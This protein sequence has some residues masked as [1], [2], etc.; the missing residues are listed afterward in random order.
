MKIDLEQIRCHNESDP[1]GV[2]AKARSVKRRKPLKN[3]KHRETEYPL[4]ELSDGDEYIGAWRIPKGWVQ[5]AARM[6]KKT[7]KT[8]I[9]ALAI[10]AKAI[11][12]KSAKIE[13]SSVEMSPWGVSQE[14]KM[15]SLQRLRDAGMIELIE[16]KN[17]SPVV[18]IK[19]PLTP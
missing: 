17:S 18:V 5:K 16:R 9:V 1:E 6:D 2:P 11:K 4:P 15:R 14:A 10:W 13:L 3:K 7:G 8:G 19:Y 12:E